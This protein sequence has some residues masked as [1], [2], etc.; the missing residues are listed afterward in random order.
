MGT[1]QD[2]PA[3]WIL[4]TRL[5]LVLGTPGTMRQSGLGTLGSMGHLDWEHWW[6]W[7][8]LDWGHLGYWDSLDV[9]DWLLQDR[10]N[11]DTL[12]QAALGG[13]VALEILN[14]GCWKSLYEGH[15]V[16]RDWGHW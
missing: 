6:S 13:L 8:S 1:D 12:A 11:W 2:K 7:G 3:C 15:R 16:S 4:G 10:V 9:G 14:W 5:Q